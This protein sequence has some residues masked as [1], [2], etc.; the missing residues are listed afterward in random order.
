MR[1]REFIALIGSTAASWPLSARAQQLDRIRRVGVLFSTSDDLEVRS[2]LAAF[3]QK[4][5]ELG[6]LE[7]RNLSLEVCWSDVTADHAA[8]C[9]AKLAGLTSDV[10]LSSGPEALLALR[11]ATGTI[12]IVFVMV[13][14]PV[15]S[16][17]VSS[18]ARPDSNVTGLAAFEYSIGGKWVELLK[19][20]APDVVRVGVLRNAAV[21]TH[22]GYLRAI[23]SAAPTLGVSV[24]VMDASN[25]DELDSL[26]NA[27][28]RESDGLIVLPSPL[29]ADHYELI[30]SQANRGKLPA[31]YPYRFYAASGGLLSYGNSVP[32]TYRQAAVQIDRILRGASVG[33]LPVQLAPKIE[34]VVNLKTAKQLGLNIPSVLLARADEVIE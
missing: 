25:A 7:G 6:W 27:I 30:V 18:L 14:E 10:I 1:R 4:L 12:P 34:L 17:V 23:E 15:E 21:F 20:V 16:G 32:E 2:H 29:S 9:A 28:A 8:A 11:Q 5:E 3:R 26:M 33:D 19:Q 24:I 13:G 31:I 22:P